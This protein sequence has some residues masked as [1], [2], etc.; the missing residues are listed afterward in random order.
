MSMS[1]ICYVFLVYTKPLAPTDVKCNRTANGYL[2]TWSY[3][4][5]PGRPQV[6]YFLIE[7]RRLNSS[8]KWKSLAT[9][10]NRERRQWTTSTDIVNPEV[11][12][13]FRMFSFGETFSEPSDVVKSSDVTGMSV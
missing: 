1:N 5:I 11:L 12:Y 8:L 13:E 10:I 4:Q 6:Q 2:I 3:H 7:Y 9:L